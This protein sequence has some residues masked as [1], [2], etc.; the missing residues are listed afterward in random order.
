MPKEGLV[1]IYWLLYRLYEC[2]WAGHWGQYK[3]AQVCV[4]H[5]SD[6]ESINKD[7]GTY[8]ILP[9]IPNLI[10]KEIVNK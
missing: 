4:L 5:S 8:I 2:Q 9:V 1:N 6:T 7:A 3:T 10:E